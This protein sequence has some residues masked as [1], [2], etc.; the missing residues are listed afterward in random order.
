MNTRL[1]IYAIWCIGLVSSSLASGN[2]EAHPKLISYEDNRIGWTWDDN[3]VEYMDF[4]LSIQYPL[5]AKNANVNNEGKALRPNTFR[6]FGGFNGR[7]AQYIETRESAPVIGKRFNP[8][9]VARMWFKDVNSYW[10][11]GYGH[12]SNGQSI[13]TE[14]AYQSRRDALISEGQDPNFANDNI[15][16]GWDYIS[17]SFVNDSLVGD[18]F[19]LK[20][21]IDLRYWL[22]D[23]FLQQGAEEVYP[24]ENRS[25]G[26]RRK[27]VD[28]IRLA[29]TYEGFQKND[30]STK[31]SKKILAEYLTFQYTTGY[32]NIFDYQTVKVEFGVAIYDVPIVIWGSSG[33]NSDIADYYKKVDSFGFA[34]KFRSF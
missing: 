1:T 18:R 33:Y 25:D 16:R 34:F 29:V 20:K 8:F 13:T 10:E 19:P 6:V 28:G 5:F 21:R 4:L 23:G 17:A 7:F 30:S 27:E 24:W 32:K 22:E 31:D 15:S 9:L 12:E 14:S 26:K 11:L 2:E 3:D